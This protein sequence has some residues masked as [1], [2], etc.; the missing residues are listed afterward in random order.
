MSDGH[1][2]GGCPFGF[3][4]TG[5]ASSSGVSMD[6]SLSNGSNTA[7]AGDVVTP[8]ANGHTELTY[9]SYLKVICLLNQFLM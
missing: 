9:S 1:I 7:S 2:S 3:G 4:R 5:S 8:N 6:A